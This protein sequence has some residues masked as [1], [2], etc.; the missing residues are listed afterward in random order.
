MTRKR[1]AT[2]WIFLLVSVIVV[3]GMGA[4]A[5]SAEER[6]SPDTGAE[7]TPVSSGTSTGA[8][9]APAPGETV[10]S[11]VTTQPQEPGTGVQVTPGTGTQ[12][13]PVE[14]G[15][16]PVAGQ[17]TPTPESAATA[18]LPSTQPPSS[19]GQTISHTVQPGDTVYSIA[20]RYGTSVEAITQANGLINPSQ[21]AVGQTL[22]IPTSGGSS[23]GSTGG[24][25]G[26]RVR[27]TVQRGEWIWQIARNYGVS[28]YD[29]MASNGMSIQT[30]RTIIPG[31]V[32]CIP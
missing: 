20:R 9:E 25:T 4:C 13:T 2:L 11:A 32:L 17:S 18:A 12:T 22:K 16:T 15:G 30:G 5:R 6:E 27:H 14:S 7:G 28:P 26:C 29:I 19:S 23:S 31:Q 21:I 3:A 24:T 1:L 8:G 10:V